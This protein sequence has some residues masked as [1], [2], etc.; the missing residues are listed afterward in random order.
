MGYIFQTKIR[1]NIDAY[2]TPKSWN[3]QDHSRVG[4]MAFEAHHPLGYNTHDKYM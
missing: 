1:Q 4:Q 3:E 2:A